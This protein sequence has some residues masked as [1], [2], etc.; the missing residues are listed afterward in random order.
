MKDD[1]TM[2]D[3]LAYSIEELAE[4]T[5]LSVPKIRKDIRNGKLESKK[6]GTR[7]I[8]LRDEAI[9]YLSTDDGPTTAVVAVA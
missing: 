8:I 9:R 1:M 4:L 7:R 3:K 6:K 2:R 5:T